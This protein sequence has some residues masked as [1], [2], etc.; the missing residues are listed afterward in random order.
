M[1][2]SDFSKRVRGVLAQA[3]EEALALGHEFIGCEHLLLGLLTSHGIG[4]TVL[5]NLGVDATQA[6]ELVKRAR[7]HGTLD[8]RLTAA[9]LPYTSPAKRT[10][11]LA[12]SE[13]RELQ[14][15]T[16]GTEHLLMGLLREE[17]G[18]AAQVLRS[19]G[20]TVEGAR[21]EMLRICSVEPANTPPVP[22]GGSP[23]R[24]S[25]SLRYSNGLVV[26]KDFS[27]AADAAR[28]L[29]AP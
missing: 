7:K 19:L 13:A 3:R 14:H 4:I 8:E 27:D 17:R 1:K 29:S 28:F 10:L 26:Q 11:E 15:S 6:S 2:G 5:R 9:D 21:A 12:M 25:L 23:I 22:M 16:L 18:I 24:V 20:V